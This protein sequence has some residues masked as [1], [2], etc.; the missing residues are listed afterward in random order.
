[1][2]EFA[3]D[4]S[5]QKEKRRKYI[6]WGGVVLLGLPVLVGAGLLLSHVLRTGGTCGRLVPIARWRLAWEPVEISACGPGGCVGL[7]IGQALC[8]GP[9]EVSWLNETGRAFLPSPT[10]GSHESP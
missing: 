1:M 8:V 7:E 10:A 2:R 5:E 9:L 3:V 6:A 4:A